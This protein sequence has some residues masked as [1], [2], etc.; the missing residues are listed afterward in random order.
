MDPPDDRV[1]S[2]AA[3]TPAAAL[4]ALA[5]YLAVAATLL[6]SALFGDDVVSPGAFFAQSGPFPVALRQQVPDGINLL[7]DRVNQFMPWLRYAADAYAIDGHLPLWKSLACCGAP[8]VGNG[9]SALFFPTNLLAILI[10]AP[11]WVHA[12]QSLVKLAAGAFCAYLLA[13]HLRLSFLAALLAG[14]VFGFGG[15]QAVFLQHPHTNVSLLLPLLLLAADR[16]VLSPSRGRVAF[17][18]L[19]AGLQHLGGHAE[20]AAHSQL[21][22]LALGL[23]RAWSLRREAPLGRRLAALLG[24]LFLG[25]ALGAIQ[26]LPQLEYIAES[27]TLELRSRLADEVAA[28]S[29]PLAPRLL[30]LAALAV[31]LVCVRH[32]ARGRRRLG[33]AA[34]AALLVAALALGLT[35][36]LSGGLSPLYVAPLAADWFGTVHDYFG[37]SN[38]VEQN[39][40]FAG[41]ALALALLGLLAGRPRGVARSAGGAL[42]I[43]LLALYTAPGLS[44][45]LGA[46]PG[47]QLAV[48][49]RLSLLALLA[50]AILAGLGL[51]VIA[52]GAGAAAGAGARVGARYALV[53]ALLLAGS[54]GV[55]AAG[56]RRG[57]ITGDVS[58]DNFPSFA[59]QPLPVGQLSGRLPPAVIG[60][61]VENAAPRR[62]TYKFFAGGFEAPGPVAG[63]L[64]MYGPANRAVSASCV[65]AKP[66][67][68]DAAAGS[69][70]RP[71]YLFVAAVPAHA[72]PAGRSTVQ[73]RAS[74]QDGNTVYSEPFQSL[75]DPDTT[76]WPFPAQPAPGRAGSQLAL[77]LLAALLCALLPH[78]AAATREA[79]RLAL[80]GAVAASL[81]PFTADMLPLLPS[82]AFYPRAGALDRLRRLAPDAR[83]IA[84][85]PGDFSA[86]I[87]V[88][89]G[90]PDVRGY[91]ALAP[92]RV[93][94]LLRQATDEPPFN[95]PMELLPHRDP[96]D[97]RLL[98]LM[99][100]RCLAAWTTA[101]PD[102]ERIHFSGELFLPDWSPFTLVSN[103]DYLPRA[104]LVGEARIE[105]DD[106]AA[107]ATLAAPDF[108]LATTVLLAGGTAPAA[109]GVTSPAA[110][111]APL[112]GA[113][114]DS[115]GFALIVRDR[116]DLVRLG[117]EARRPCW[118]VLADTFFPGWTVTVDGEPREIARANL[119]FRAVAVGP[120]DQVVEFRYEPL[121]FRGGALLSALAALAL[122]A[123][124]GAALLTRRAPPAT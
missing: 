109:G 47:L 41:A 99:A 115:L 70:G 57:E 73:L 26:I 101:P 67:S 4:L 20:T 106:E 50:T 8:L 59:V 94:R 63:A 55:L 82:G 89:Y 97:L 13:R 80:V 95:W 85:V 104:R 107:L 72:F 19:V 54:F 9:Q 45:L 42:A 116:P 31:A 6:Q 33:L 93:A 65:L 100:V 48:N 117:V 53:F 56:A 32:L 43:G 15:F 66:E 39:G 7:S 28:A 77:L 61:L 10:G 75:D 34:A 102:L 62:E 16:A 58:P 40:A 88:W 27:E 12:A 14:L 5:V 38:Y 3:A 71:L 120:G 60:R 23:V 119:A 37:T 64:L 1:A 36:G 25:A 87:P 118:L 68:E 112:S 121:S 46:L 111:A 83:M 84:M 11:D 122:L 123:A 90:I 110:S 98:G 105:P 92:R 76:A 69:D 113:P 96:P 44:E 30:F 103:P 74:L 51:D 79:G 22:A 124:G 2:P 108:P 91:D 86:E 78:A 24:G 17:L 114:V 21:A 52:R 49:T 35:A 29:Q 81:L 18:A